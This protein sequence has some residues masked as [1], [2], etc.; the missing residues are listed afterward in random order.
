MDWLE[1]QKTLLKADPCFISLAFGVTLVNIALKILRWQ[2]QLK[3]DGQNIQA[4]GYLGLFPLCSNV[5]RSGPD[6]AG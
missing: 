5:E 1:V 4:I 3:P 2:V 6:P